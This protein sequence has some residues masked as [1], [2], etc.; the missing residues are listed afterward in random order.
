MEEI[1]ID[2]LLEEIK[3]LKNRIKE[4][5]N[6]SSDQKIGQ[7]NLSAELAYRTI[8]RMSP[9]TL[10]VSRLEDGVIFDVSDSFCQKS[11][12]SREEAIGKTAT[13][14]G[15][16]QGNEREKMIKI[17][18]NDGGYRNQEV[19]H[20]IK[21]GK[22]LVCLQSAELITIDDEHYIIIVV[23]DITER[24]M[25]EERLRESE[26]KYRQLFDNAPVGI[27]QIDFKTARFLNVNEVFCK[28]I[29][30]SQEEVTSLTAFDILTEESKKI[31]LERAGKISQGIKVPD[32][33]VLEVLN[34][35]GKLSYVQLNIRN[36]YDT[37]GHVITADVVAYDIT[38]RKLAENELKRFAEDLEDAN[39]ALRVVMNQR[40]IDQKDFEEKLQTNIN[41]LVMPYVKKIKKA[42]PDDRIMK[43]MSILEKNLQDVLSPFMRDFQSA[44]KNLT[45]QEIHIV[46]MIRNGKSSKDI[47]KILNAS[48]HTI[49][50]HRNNIRK[51]LRLVN[52]K[53]NLRSHIL[54][55]K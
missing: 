55:L 24:K 41:E 39:I 17:L 36:I 1:N 35:Q 28:H 44:Y 54:S 6:L 52:S 32:T 43:Y 46:D 20:F 9:N 12:F 16:W 15:L 29:G 37:E 2:N 31:F 8:F 5:E 30:Y 42:D 45:P 49:M 51:K 14:L 18:R 26:E 40:N 19:T 7:T 47:A 38:E 53:T 25:M 3:A 11:G 21:N 4:L 48:E 23:V 34:K 27:Y 50:T 13:Q 33:V 10:V 22:K